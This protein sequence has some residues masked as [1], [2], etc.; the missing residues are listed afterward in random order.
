MRPIGKDTGQSSSGS[1]KGTALVMFQTQL[2]VRQ[3]TPQTPAGQGRWVGWTQLLFNRR[4]STLAQSI[5]L[6]NEYPT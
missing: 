4:W 6:L 5:S 1:A 2:S 3:P